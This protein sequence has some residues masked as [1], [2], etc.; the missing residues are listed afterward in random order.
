[1]LVSFVD[2]SVGDRL[3]FDSDPETWLVCV[4]HKR[5]AHPSG[6]PNKALHTKEFWPVQ[7]P[8]GDDEPTPMEWTTKDIDE[9]KRMRACLCGREVPEWV[10]KTRWRALTAG[11]CAV[12][13]GATR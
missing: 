10:Q 2:V 7:P 8:K 12:R 5:T 3:V 13:I 9:R 1:M 6:D 11:Y 4:C